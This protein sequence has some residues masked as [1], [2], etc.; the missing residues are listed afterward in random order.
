[1]MVSNIRE[2]LWSKIVL[3]AALG[4]IGSLTHVTVGEFR[5]VPETRRILSG[6]MQEVVRIAA[7]Q[8]IKLDVDCVER[9]LDFVDAMPFESRSSLQRDIAEGRPSELEY[10]IGDLV[11]YS[12]AARVDAP[13]LGWAYSCLRATELKAQ[14][15]CGAA[16]KG[17]AVLP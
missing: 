12:I 9:T 11:R 5:K 8:E 10:V 17:T 4:A 1:M 14:L 16:S 6:I 2:V 15:F 13:L 7:S 3:A